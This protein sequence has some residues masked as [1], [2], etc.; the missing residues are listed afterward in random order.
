MALKQQNE[1]I[2]YQGQV[3]LLKKQQGMRLPSNE[4]HGGGL[5]MM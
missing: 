4:R 1:Y 5:M 2:Y 3:Y